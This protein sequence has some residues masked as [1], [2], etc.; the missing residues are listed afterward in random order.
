[1]PVYISVIDRATSTLTRTKPGGSESKFRG[2]L[3]LPIAGNVL[4]HDSIC[5]RVARAGFPVSAMGTAELE[6][7]IVRILHMF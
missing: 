6:A 3:R 1:M 7:R 5:T 2:C 4:C